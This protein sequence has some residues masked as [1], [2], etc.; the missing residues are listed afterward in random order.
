MLIR[1][2]LLVLA[3]T[4]AAPTVFAQALLSAPQP[5]ATSL[6]PIFEAI[7]VKHDTPA[8]STKLWTGNIHPDGYSAQGITPMFLMYA[9]N[10]AP[11]YRVI[12][13]PSWWDENHYDIQ[14]KVGEAD[15]AAFQRLS[16]PQRNAMVQQVLTERFKLKVHWETRVQPIYSLVVDR[17]GVLTD[18][19]P[20]ADGVKVFAMRPGRGDRAGQMVSTDFS[21][22]ALADNLS[23]MLGRMV[24]DDTG[25]TGQYHADLHWTW[26]SRVRGGNASEQS[27]SSALQEQ[28]GLKLVPG[29]GPVKFLVIDHVEFPSED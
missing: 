24:I 6:V 26:D 25:L 15:L 1:R 29:E 16:F 2:T 4:I 18:A 19:P 14:A 7:S 28:G 17:E 23:G 5:T 21:L 12:G 20:R 10:V 3:V 8:E 22:P 27:I 13:A 11:N 9:Y